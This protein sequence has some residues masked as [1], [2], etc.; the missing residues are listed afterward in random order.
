MLAARADTVFEQPFTHPRPTGGPDIALTNV[1]A[2][3]RPQETR[4]ILLVTHWDTRGRADRSPIESHRTRSVPGANDGA[5]GVAVLIELAELFRT[6]PPPV[7]VDLLFTDGAEI[8]SSSTA[9]GASHFLATRPAGYA[10]EYVI[11]L[12]RV[13]DLDPRFPLGTQPTGVAARIY[14]LAQG[15]GHEASFPASAPPTLDHGDHLVLRTS[16]IPTILIADGEYG[17]GNA[18]WRTANDL[19]SNTQAESLAAVGEVI[20]ELIYRG[21]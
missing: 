19:P 2:R 5:S 17:P 20:A 3:F 12:E 18:Y 9:P 10:P 14:S 6:Q 11:V 1:V 13:G 21:G 16:G 15:L 7:G 8:G 4:R